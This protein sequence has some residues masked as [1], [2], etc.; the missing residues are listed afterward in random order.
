M[1]EIKTVRAIS[2]NCD[3]KWVIR[4]ELQHNRK[5]VQDKRETQP[6]TLYIYWYFPQNIQSFQN[7]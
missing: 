2:I 5:C 3:K 1:N 7:Q 6:I 4:K